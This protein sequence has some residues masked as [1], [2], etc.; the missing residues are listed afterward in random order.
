MRSPQ[1]V[2]AR[3]GRPAFRKNPHKPTS[4]TTNSHTGT[5]PHFSVVANS[6]GVLARIIRNSQNAKAAVDT[7]VR[8]KSRLGQALRVLHQTSN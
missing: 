7:A 4:D 5:C 6:A 8:E 3:L 2:H 1:T